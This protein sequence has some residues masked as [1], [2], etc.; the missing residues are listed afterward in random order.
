MHTH[1]T[2]GLAEG[3]TLSVEDRVEPIRRVLGSG[4]AMFVIGQT[5]K[6][7]HGEILGGHYVNIETRAP[8][9]HQG[10]MLPI[11]GAGSFNSRVDRQKS[12]TRY[13]VLQPSP[14]GTAE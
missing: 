13:G 6:R 8:E 4:P 2:P 7:E 10:R 14:S 5:P 12:G 11:G 3:H 9:L 1:S